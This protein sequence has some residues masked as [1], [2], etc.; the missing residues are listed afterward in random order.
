M[1]LLS[2]S[3]INRPV[4][5]LRTGGQV[6]KVVSPL[7]NPDNL[8][9]EGFYC[10]DRFSKQQ[11]IL[12][13]QDIRD[14]LKQGYVINDHDV[15]VVPEELIRLK[16][17]LRINYQLMDKPVYTPDKKKLGKVNDY[18]A[19]SETMYVQK[20]YVGQSVLKTLS[21]GQLSIDRGQIIEITSRRI[22]VQDPLQPLDAAA[23]AAVPVIS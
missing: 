4:L 8:K 3:L 19:D 18:A 21:G 13:V 16:K 10:D 17:V 6:A 23:P 7:F 15:L 22:I 2:R 11:L 12:L 5:S 1:L 9:I 20:I 14:T